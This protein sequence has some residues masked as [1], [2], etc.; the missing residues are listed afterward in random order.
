MER[1]VPR[2]SFSSVDGTLIFGSGATV[3]VFAADGNTSV[4]N[5]HGTRVTA[6]SISPNG[7]WVA[8]GD[9][10]G[11]VWKMINVGF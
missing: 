7:L 4:V 3:S 2:N 8:T 6:A 9:S 11:M 5:H 10:K 1:G